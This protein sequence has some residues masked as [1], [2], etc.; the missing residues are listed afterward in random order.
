[1]KVALSILTRGDTIDWRAGRAKSIIQSFVHRMVSALGQEHEMH[2]VTDRRFVFEE[3][4]NAAGP[5]PLTVHLLMEENKG[6]ST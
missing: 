1:M 2:I 5:H 6:L 4:R 3:Y